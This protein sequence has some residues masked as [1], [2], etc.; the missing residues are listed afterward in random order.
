MKINGF[1][2]TVMLTILLLLAALGG[3]THAQDA[4]DWMPD[5]NLRRAVREKLE[6]PDAIPMLPAD[7][8]RLYDLVVL[9]SDIASLQGLE[10]AVNIT[11]LHIGDSHISDLTP[12]IGLRALKVLKLYNNQISDISPLSALIQIQVLELHN[13][14]ISDISPLSSLTALEYL[15]LHDNQ[16]SDFT[17][18]LNLRNLEFLDIRDNLDSGVGQFVSANPVVID[19]LRAT[20]CEFERPQ[21]TLPVQDRIDNRDYPSV[22]TLNVP[23]KNRE[24]LEPLKRLSVTDLSF[25]IHPFHEVGTLGFEQSPIGYIARVGNVEF[26]KQ[27]HADVLSKNP[28]MLFL[29]EIAYFDGRGFGFP[30]DSSYW[31]R[32]PD[33]AIARRIWYIDAQGNEYGEPLV[34]FVNPEVQEMIIAQAVA[35]ARCGLYD[36]IWLDRWHETGEVDLRDYFPLDVELSARDQILQGIRQHVPDDFLILVNATWS[37]IPRWASSVNGV[38]MESWGAPDIESLEAQGDR[39]THQ[40]F[41]NYE[42]ALIWNEAN[43]RAPNFTLL[44]GKYPTYTDPHSPRSLQTMRTFTTL[45]LTHSDGYVSMAQHDYGGIW[46]DFYDA[47]LGRPIGERGQT[48]KSIDGLFIREFTNGW[49]VYNRSGTAQEVEFSEEVSGWSSG[50][51]NQHRHALADLDGEIY[52]KVETPPTAD[53]NADGTVNIL[54]LVLVANAFGKSAPDVN[55]DGTVNVLDLVLVANAF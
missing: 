44:F 37:K 48:Y 5:P 4:K 51:E 24:D 1:I 10:H 39:Y 46:Y 31:L 52:L 17:S 27:Q 15:N 53:V 47:D 50:V 32:T 35:V 29:V 36:G 18:L 25:G 42:E 23:I 33:G 54:D 16:I 45:S 40:D 43:L 6:T 19:A 8:M 22:F 41:R 38:L 55:G 30:E 21:Y 20:I 3:I 9:E 49:A 7:L 14:Q 11:F 26:L 2:S 28:N 12:L 13:N 34:D